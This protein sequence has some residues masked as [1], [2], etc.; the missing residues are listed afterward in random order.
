MEKIIEDKMKDSEDKVES[1]RMSSELRTISNKIE[2]MRNTMTSVELDEVYVPNTNYHLKRWA[3]NN[4]KDFHRAYTPS[5]T[6]DIIERIMQINDIEDNWKLLL[7][8]GIGVFGNQKSITYNEI[9]KEL[10]YNQ[11]LYLII[12]DSDYIYG[13]N[14]QFCHGY[15]SKDLERMTQEKCIQAMGRIGR[16]KLQYDYSIRFRGNNL[17]HK[18]FMHDDNK[19]EV[20]NMNR[21]FASD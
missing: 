10:A 14:Y 16:N 5:I 15:I 20:K 6:S 1:G 4:F 12:A 8:M 9:M 7:M 19:P 18:I 17:F 2:D 13:T 21:L 3:P 11:Q